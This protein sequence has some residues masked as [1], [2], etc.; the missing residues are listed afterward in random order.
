[1]LRYFIRR[2][3]LALPTMFIIS[4]A[5]FVMARYSVTDPTNS[6]EYWTKPEAFQAQARKLGLDRP[7]FYF[8]VSNAAFPDT[9]HRILPTQRRNHLEQLTRRS[10]NWTASIQFLDAVTVRLDSDLVEASGPVLLGFKFLRNFDR[11]DQISAALKKLDFQVD[12]LRNEALR[13]RLK[14]QLV[15]IKAS[16]A[17]MD[18]RQTQWKLYV[19][20]VHWHG[21]NNLYHE[22]LSSFLSGDP[23]KSSV[24]GNSMLTE[25]RPR[26]LVTLLI[27]GVA[28]LLAYLIGVPLGVAMA[29]RYQRPF[30]R[31]TRNVLMFLYAMPVIW[32]GSLLVLLLSKP[33]MGLNLFDGLN[34]E[35]LL[36][37]GK[38]FGVWAWDNRLKFILPILTLTLHSLAILAMQMRSGILEVIKQDFIRTA[39]AKGLS[40]RLVYWRHAFRNALFP[41]ITIF[42]SLFPAVFSGS[43]II[44][45]LFDFPGMGSKM[46]S[47]F[48][49]NDYA[50][51]FAMVMFVA[52]VTI[53][54]SI[55]ADLLYA[56]A[57]PRVRYAKR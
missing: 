29:R 57:D 14:A 55:L 10:G 19:P 20:A 45:Y 28:M 47:A 30:D 38:P 50:V 22:W 39:R 32:V 56:W 4:L 11:L 5:T 1:M 9:L 17:E 49:N 18:G 52:I 46:Q 36:L 51:L 25:L 15:Q 24:T 26:L 27:N 31:W 48:I 44:E 7:V 3:L 54:S 43:L 34:A 6:D 23:G 42:A 21:P 2:L 41:V 40:E 53:L 16:F 37:S 33:D 12:T 35:P 8:S 13:S